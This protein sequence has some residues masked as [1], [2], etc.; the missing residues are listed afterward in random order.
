LEWLIPEYGHANGDEK[1][2]IKGTK[3]TCPKVTFTVMLPDTQVVELLGHVDKEQSHQNVLVVKTPRL[4]DELRNYQGP[5]LKAEVRV[6][7]GRAGTCSAPLPFYYI[8]NGK[9]LGS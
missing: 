2:V 6:S 4:P 8:P 1:I 7:S 9:Q 5:T 3:M